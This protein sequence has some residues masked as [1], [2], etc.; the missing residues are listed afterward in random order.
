VDEPVVAWRPVAGEVPA[1]PSGQ[2]ADAPLEAG[3]ARSRRAAPACGHSGDHGEPPELRALRGPEHPDERR[4]TVRG[5]GRTGTR[6][7]RL[8]RREPQRAPVL[9]R[10]RPDVRRRVSRRRGGASLGANPLYRE[11]GCL[12]IGSTP[13]GTP[14]API[15][16]GACPAGP[17]CSPV[18]P[19]GT[20]GAVV[21]CG[22]TT[23][24]PNGYAF[25]DDPS[26]PFPGCFPIACGGS[27]PTC[28]GACLDGGTCSP[29]AFG[30]G[31]CICAVAAPCGAGGYVCPPGQVCLPNGSCGSP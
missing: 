13:C 16:G 10:L 28:G 30:T 26:F 17:Q 3:R 25:V 4:R 24:C 15:C 22:C 11:C 12:P 18:F 2:G 23:Q 5:C 19:P 7:G 8:L 21:E 9:Q 20:S 29:F 14:N 27:Y 31:W 1:P 6:A